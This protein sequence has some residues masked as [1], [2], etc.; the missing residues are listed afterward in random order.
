MDTIQTD[1]DD[2]QGMKK[3]HSKLVIYGKASG[4]AHE[5]VETNSNSVSTRLKSRRKSLSAESNVLE[6]VINEKLQNILGQSLNKSSILIKYNKLSKF[7]IKENTPLKIIMDFI[8]GFLTYYSVITSLMY[9]GYEGPSNEQYQFDIFVWV[10]FIIDFFLS[11]LVE[12][13]DKNKIPVRNFKLI[14]KNYA[15]TWMIFDIVSL[16]PLHWAEYPDA[17]YL[18][19][20]F[21]ILKLQRL[22]RIV[23][24][25]KFNNLIQQY[26]KMKILKCLEL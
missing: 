2:F 24:K 17:E 11:F 26:F 4:D 20:L 25:N 9:L 5:T 18:L 10:L 7:T 3:Y 8:M 15:M 16:L 6:N 19:R 13:K 1:S 21:R 22:F 12:Y 14:A 23:S